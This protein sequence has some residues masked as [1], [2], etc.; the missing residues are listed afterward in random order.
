M[1]SSSK[2]PGKIELPVPEAWPPIC[3]KEAIIFP[4]KSGP[5]T[6]SHQKKP[7]N[8][9]KRTNS[10]QISIKSARFKPIAIHVQAKDIVAKIQNKWFAAPW[11]VE[12]HAWPAFW[13][14]LNSVL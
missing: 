5:L 10:A 11:I 1:P 8:M 6:S 7:V 14:L 9:Q 3:H 2:S 4:A 13:N 12:A